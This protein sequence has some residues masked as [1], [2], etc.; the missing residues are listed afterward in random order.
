MDVSLVR[1]D[2]RIAC[3]VSITTTKDWELGGI[4]KCFTAGYSEVLL[5]GRTERHI[6]SLSK[7]IEKNLDPKNQEQV[8]YVTSE[9]LIEYLDGF[10]KPP[11][12]EDIVSWIHCEN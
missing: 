7:F 2:T 8:K 11:P 1:N 5:I 12:S 4:E 3:Q 9:G 10:G 6:N